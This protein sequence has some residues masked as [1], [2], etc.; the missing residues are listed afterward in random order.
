MSYHKTVEQYLEYCKFRK[1]LDWNTLKAY[2]IDL[3][4]FFEYVQEDIP[5]KVTVEAYITE[6]HKKYKPK[7]IKRKIAS[8]RTYYSYL[9]E[10]EI[11]QSNPF[12]K[13]KV[14]FKEISLL[15]R[16][17]PREEIEKLLNYMYINENRKS[18]K[19]YKFWLRDVAMIEIFFATGARVYEISNI[20]AECVNLNSGLIKIMG[21]GG[22]ERYIQVVTPEILEILKKYYM[23]N[24]KEIKKSGFFFI[25]SRGTRYTEQSIRLMMKKYARMAGIERNITPHM[26]RHSFATYL[27]EE[28]VDVSCVQQILGHSS[29]KTTQI[30]IHIAAKKQAEILK[31]LHPRNR[32]N[33]LKVA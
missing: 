18:E 11:I 27:I 24:C 7:T 9:E 32:M 14:K 2:R 25:N 21:K 13:I 31:E 10:N 15:P 5:E 28:G 12:R 17:I 19:A 1:E 4:Q 6:L 23:Y 3:K 30:Y 16:I 26:F 29:I 20:K 8:V 22:K 33:I